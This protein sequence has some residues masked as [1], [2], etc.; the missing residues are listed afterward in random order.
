[1]S[2]GL[3]KNGCI[4]FIAAVIFAFIEGG[5]ILRWMLFNGPAPSLRDLEAGVSVFA[6]IWLLSKATDWFDTREKQHKE[7]VARIRDIDTRLEALYKWG[8]TVLNDEEQDEDTPWDDELDDSMK[9][10]L[11][12]YIKDVEHGDSGSLYSLGVTYW[13]LAMPHY[14]A[15]NAMG[16]RKAVFWLLKAAKRDYDCENTLGDAYLNLGEYDKAMYWYLKSVK[17]GGRLVWIAES[18]IG[19]MYAEGH[20][21]MQNYAEA[22]R[23]WDR[24]AQHGSDWAHYSLGKLYAEGADGVE[25]DSHKA[26]FH[27]YIASS[28]TGEH[29]PQESAVKGCDK[30]EK[31]LGQYFVSQE[32]KREEEWLAAKKE[33]VRQRPQSKV[34]PLPLP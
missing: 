4:F 27:L 24:A 25:K 10:K 1:M 11:S 12:K 33:L 16:Y 6:L 22:A 7:I 20:G 23:W 29:G 17:R 5:T 34:Q 8:S 3:G 32:K 13:N 2:K 14:N 19:D 9:T 30:V 28:A 18:S 31:E 26:Y 21:I 15:H